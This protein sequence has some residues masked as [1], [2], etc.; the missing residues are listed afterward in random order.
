MCSPAF[1]KDRNVSAS[2]PSSQTTPPFILKAQKGR[3]LFHHVAGGTCTL[4]L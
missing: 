1:L 2:P 4:N 3:S